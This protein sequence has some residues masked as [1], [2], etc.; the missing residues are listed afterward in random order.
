MSNRANRQGEGERAWRWW[1][2]WEITESK[3]TFIENSIHFH[4]NMR[5]FVK[6]YKRVPPVVEVGTV[7]DENINREA[8]VKD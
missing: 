6:D 2:R 5:W 4:D 3:Y 7:I 1:K 8:L